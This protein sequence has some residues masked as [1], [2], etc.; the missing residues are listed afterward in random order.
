MKKLQNKLAI[1]LIKLDMKN[2]KISKTIGKKAI[3]IIEREA[4]P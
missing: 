4:R 2:K 3:K 1:Y